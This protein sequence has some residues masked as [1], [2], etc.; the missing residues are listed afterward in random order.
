M[1]ADKNSVMSFTAKLIDLE[2]TASCPAHIV[3]D[4]SEANAF[5]HRFDHLNAPVL[6]AFGADRLHQFGTSGTYH[7]DRAIAENSATLCRSVRRLS[8]DDEQTRWD[9]LTFRF[10]PRS[11]LYMDASRLVGYAESATEA[12]ELVTRFRLAYSLPP[13]P[14]GGSFH[15]ITTGNNSISTETVPLGPDTIL[16]DATLA[17]HYGYDSQQWNEQFT[18]DMRRRIHG[19][20]I[21]EGP[22]GTGKTSYLRHL[23]G[24]LKETHRFYFIP[25]ASL[26]VLSKPDFIS[27]WA[28]ER[29]HHDKQKFVVILE[30]SDEALMTRAADNRDQVSAILNLS[31]GML[32][33]FLRL[34]IIC[35]INC[36][37]A[38]IDPALLRPGRLLC[39]RIFRRLNHAEASPLA[40][41]LGRT[42]AEGR[43]YSLA[44]IFAHDSAALNPR[45]RIGFT[46]TTP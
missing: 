46:T 22:P 21:F 13:K 23:M 36:R 30:D 1:R 10:G 35:T 25:T 8:A 11:Y 15:L 9:D 20:T 4:I 6:A 5:S 28:T 31:D 17:L 27:F 7:L 2:A 41:R 18:T 40:H 19:L 29:R 24:V 38:D 45:R 16:D 12:E 39:H 32:A 26:G 43:D 34:Q 33:D 37:A 3:C 42:L 44:E 14:K